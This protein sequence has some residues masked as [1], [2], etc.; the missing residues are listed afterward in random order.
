VPE[1]V[2]MEQIMIKK[3][4]E[5][6]IML[7]I[8]FSSICATAGGRYAGKKVLYVDSYHVGYAWSD[9]I[10]EGIR[11]TLKD[12]GVELK[13]IEM[14][15]KRNT[16]EEFKKAAALNVR[17]V[18]AE[19]NPDVVIASD[20]NASK[21]LIMPYYKDVDLPFVF[22]GLNWDASVYGFPFKNV[23]G[24]VEIALVPQIIKQLRKYARGDRIGFLGDDTFTS[25][26]NLQYHRDLLK[27]NYD[28]VYYAKN[29]EEWQAK[30]IELQDQVDML[31]LINYVGIADWD[32]EKAQVFV[33]NYTKIPT[34][35]NNTW[36]MPFSL[37]GIIKRPEEQ[38]GWAAHAALK[39]LDGTPPA[40]IP[41]T[42]N[43][44]GKLYYNLRIGKKLGITNAPAGA[45]VAE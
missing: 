11:K 5:V 17:A 29:F 30:Y 18:I 33:E 23:T 20:D 36:T 25:R 42:H 22:C 31:I 2:E 12:T 13:R 38:G 26:K 21:Y 4:V 3:I 10:A 16:S 15:T 28:H 14:D 6:I 39:I 1:V 45:I 32:K 9:G 27:I 40:K 34:V 19:F 41:I 43:K 44:Q 24:M 37:L 35:T 7:L 8:I